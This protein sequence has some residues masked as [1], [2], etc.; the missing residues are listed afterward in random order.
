MARKKKQQR[1]QPE[2]NYEHLFRSHAGL[3][4]EEDWEQFYTSRGSDDFFEWYAEWPQIQSLL[5]DQLLS[6][7]SLLPESSGAAAAPPAVQPGELKILVPG[8]GSSKLSEHLY[9][10]GF[11]QITNVDFSN[12]VIENMSKRNSEQRPE[13]TW[14]SND[15]TIVMF[16]GKSFHD[17]VDKGLLDALMV[18]KLGS[19]GAS[20]ILYMSNVGRIL[21]PGGKFICFT[22]PE[23]D[24]LDVL[25][26]KFRF[27]W[28]TSLYTISE[29]LHTI[30]VVV[31]KDMCASVS[32]I[33]SNM[34]GYS[35]A[36]HGDKARQLNKAL[37]KERKFRS[38][39]SG[40]SVLRALKDLNLG[41][42]EEYVPGRR[43]KLILGEPEGPYFF[44]GLLL[45]A[46]QDPLSI[47]FVVYVVPR[48]IAEDWYFSSEEGQNCLATNLKAGRVLL[49][50]QDSSNY[51]T[52]VGFIRLQIDHLLKQ[53]SP[54]HCRDEDRTTFMLPDE[55][56]DFRQQKVI[57]WAKSMLTGTITVDE[58]VCRNKHSYGGDD[59]S[60]FRRLTF[61]RSCAFSQSKA[62]LS[63][64]ETSKTKKKGKQNKSGVTKHRVDLYYLTFPYHNV[65]I[66]GLMLISPHLKGSIS[67]GSKVETVV[68]GLGGG[69]LPMFMKKQL[70][71][72]NIQVVEIDDVVLD[73]AKKYFDFTEDERLRVSIS[74][75]VKFIRDKADSQA[76]GESSRKIDIL[77]VDVNSSSSSS[78]LTFPS[79]DFV[80][81]TFLQNA[82]NSLSDEGL[83]VM[84]LTCWDP[85]LGAA[86]HWIL[87]TVFGEN[88][89]SV[90]LNDDSPQEVVFAVKNDCWMVTK[91]DISKGCS[92]LERSLQK[93]DSVNRK[94]TETVIKASKSM[95]KRARF[96]FDENF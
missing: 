50:F 86:I 92:K 74:D 60:V 84:N 58:V 34:D 40:G 65:I 7:S 66:S 18:P 91:D 87:K 26:Y 69:S 94:W 22:V 51:Y 56:G 77:I 59:G 2:E 5:T 38:E 85:L 55:E 46:Q 45:D 52:S 63:S 1:K 82:K 88:L 28:K 30:M 80:D 10:A 27:G 11:K 35:V 90:Q 72:L 96:D 23:F 76:E 20:G 81:E 43:I 24:I 41:E 29:K 17:V 32:E 49:I 36:N 57:H 25:F 47:P 71:T 44:K 79:A 83:F 9:D 93:Q 42:L 62:L 19:N 12:Y 37:E 33:S 75:G 8:C 14:H 64:Q 95:V 61:E 48:T 39:Y 6:P 68:I 31:E 78:P 15:M 16:P 70:P 89:L 73:V 21:K 53:L 67:T 3:T 13:M 54:S 4:S